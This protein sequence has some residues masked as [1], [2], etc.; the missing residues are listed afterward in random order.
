MRGPWDV[1]RTRKALHAAGMLDEIVDTQLPLL[2]ALPEGSRRRSASYLAELVMLA[3]HYRHYAAGWIDKAELLRRS[4]HTVSKL[5]EHR[6]R[7][8]AAA[9]VTDLD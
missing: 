5:D 7:R 6:A 4:H 1:W 3:Q 9:S 2:A 8:S